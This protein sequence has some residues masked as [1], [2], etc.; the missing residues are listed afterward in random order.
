MPRAKPL[1][2][3]SVEIGNWGRPPQNEPHSIRRFNGR[4]DEFMIFGEALDD[5][6]IRQLF[7]VGKISQ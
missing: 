1:R 3:G 4:M 2:G 5:T 6:A 7:Q